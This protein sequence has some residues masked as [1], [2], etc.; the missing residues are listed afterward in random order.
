MMARSIFLF[1]YAFVS[2]GSPPGLN[3]DKE[4]DLRGAYGVGYECIIDGSGCAASGQVE[5]GSCVSVGN[6]TGNY[7][8]TGTQGNASCAVPDDELRCN[9][10][11]KQD[12]GGEVQI[13]RN[14]VWSHYDNPPYGSFSCGDYDDCENY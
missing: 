12:C 11:V 10:F 5:A 9:Q 2:G 4:W 1:A 13:C 8:C 14:G 3:F 6:G 7:Y